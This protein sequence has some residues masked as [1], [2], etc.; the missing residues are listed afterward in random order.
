MGDMAISEGLLN[1]ILE[2]EALNIK[3]NL[4]RIRIIDPDL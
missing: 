2:N 1:R 4:R 3:S